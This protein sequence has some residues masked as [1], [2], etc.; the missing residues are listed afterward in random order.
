MAKDTTIQIVKE[1]PKIE[2][3]KLALLKEAQAL[4]QKDLAD[5]LPIYQIAGMDPL[6]TRALELAEQGIGAYEPYMTDADVASAASYGA[7]TSG[8]D[9]SQLTEL[10]QQY[11]TPYMDAVGSEINRAYDIQQ[12][13]QTGQ[14]IGQGA[15]GGSRAALLQNE[16]DR[17]RVG[18]L[19]KAQA[20]AYMNAQQAASG[21]MDRSLQGGQAL[22]TLALQQA[23]LGELLQQLGQRETQ[24]LYDAGKAQQAQDQAVLEAERMSDLQSLYQPYQ[25]LA[26]LSDIYKGAP[27][28]QMS[29]TSTTAPQAS[30]FQTYLGLG[31]GG[32]SAAA[33]AK[34]AGLF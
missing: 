2:A 21:M 32:L 23:G 27:S 5:E 3:Y 25:N 22:G 31:I 10:T 19:A 26:F 29:L 6:Q 12:A 13:Q 17:D 14:S 16:I 7:L 4:S 18:A 24:Y 33:G 20:D 9:P 30:P 28:S 1:D 11:M 34:E 15:F 8:V